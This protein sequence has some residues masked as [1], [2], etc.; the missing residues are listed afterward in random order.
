MTE[1]REIAE[2]E[3]NGARVRL[4]KHYGTSALTCTS[5]L[6]SERD[7][8]AEGMVEATTIVFGALGH[9]LRLR[10]I[11]RLGVVDSA[12]PNELADHF[13]V[14]QQNISKHLKTLAQAGLVKRRQDGSSAIYSIRDASITTIVDDAAALALR[15]LRELSVD[16]GAGRRGRRPP[17]PGGRLIVGAVCVAAGPCDE[18]HLWE[19]GRCGG[20]AD[21]ESSCR[22]RSK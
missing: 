8:I 17:K 16:C 2:I 10:I 4:Y 20:R 9:Q 3:H 18:R 19:S 14:P 21:P 13:G 1:Q 5:F 15:G 6:V 12:T 11:D 22:S 7:G